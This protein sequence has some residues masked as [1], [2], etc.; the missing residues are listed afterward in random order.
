MAVPQGA[1]AFNSAYFDG[2]DA[3][4]A[5]T[6]SC[7]GLQR[8]A[9]TIVGSINGTVNAVTSQLALVQSDY[10]QLATRISTLEDHIATMVASST[11]FA[12]LTTQAGTVSSAV[13]LGS[14]IAYLNAQATVHV[15]LGN[16]GNLSFLK[17]ALKLAQ[18]LIEVETAYAR[19]ANQI[20]S[21]TAL[22]TDIPTRL[23]SLETSIAAK[24]AAIGNC[25]I[26]F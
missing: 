11:A 22:L 10:N 15:S 8:L 7:G 20:T 21:L 5:A 25:T 23:S 24:A 16:A 1:S 14:V 18:E 6:A 13:D 9:T 4:V 2:L 12:G 3:S 17:Q 26:T 19:L